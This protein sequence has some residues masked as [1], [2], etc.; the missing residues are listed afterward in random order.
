MVPVAGLSAHVTLLPAGRFR[1]ENCSVP[2]GATVA[3][4]GAT[5]MAGEAVK[6]K[7]AVPRTAYWAEFVAN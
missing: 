6:V 1:T 5:L 4:D 3:V 2:A 7:L